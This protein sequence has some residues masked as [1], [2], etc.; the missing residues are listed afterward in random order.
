MSSY[1]LIVLTKLHTSAEKARGCRRLLAAPRTDGTAFSSC[2]LTYI[3][4]A[5]GNCNILQCIQRH[6]LRWMLMMLCDLD[7]DEEILRQIM[8]SQQ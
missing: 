6:W 7:V 5:N 8:T 4:E 2:F 1:V 3:G